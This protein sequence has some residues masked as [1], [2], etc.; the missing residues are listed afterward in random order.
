MKPRLKPRLATLEEVKIIKKGIEKFS[1]YYDTMGDFVRKNKDFIFKLEDGYL[2]EYIHKGAF[3]DGEFIDEFIDGFLKK[4]KDYEEPSKSR[5]NLLMSDSCFIV[6]DTSFKFKF[7]IDVSFYDIIEDEKHSEHEHSNLN[8]SKYIL[9]DN[10]NM[11]S[12][13]EF[14]DDENMTIF[15]YITERKMILLLACDIFERNRQIAEYGSDLSE[16]DF[17]DSD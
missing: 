2:N 1:F 10:G 16:F 7:V 17:S 11:Y 9:L 3:P 14:E 6:C 5:L 8:V 15:S 4:T 13:V 12:I